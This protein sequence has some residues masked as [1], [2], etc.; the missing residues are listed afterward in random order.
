MKAR[1][2]VFFDNYF[3]WSVKIDGETVTVVSL[4]VAGNVTF[5]HQKYK[6]AFKGVGV[7]SGEQLA[8]QHWDLKT[9][10]ITKEV[11]WHV[12]KN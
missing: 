9:G 10:K 12:K 6:G 3:D 7:V 4:H 8:E 5:T 2:K 11:F 1:E